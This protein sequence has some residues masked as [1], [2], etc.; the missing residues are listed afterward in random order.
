MDPIKFG[1]DLARKADLAH[2][3]AHTDF[4]WPD[5]SAHTLIITGMGSSAF[6]AQNVVTR[7]QNFGHNAIF[8]L[9]SNP[10]PPKPGTDKVLIA[11]SATGNSVET[12]AAFDNA[13][14]FKSKYWL[15]N[16][17]TL[18]ENAIAMRSGVESGGVACLSYL[19]T[20]IALLKLCE[21]LGYIKGLSNS[22]LL[23]AEA[24]ADIT[25][26]KE[27]WLPQLIDHINSPFG[28]YFI[29]PNDRICSAQQSALV[30]RECPRLPAVA[31]ETGDWSHIDVYLTK[32]IDYRAILFP[33]SIWQEQLLNWTTQR[34]TKVLTIGF[35][36]KS[37]AAILRYK[38]DLDPIVRLLAEITFIELLAQKIWQEN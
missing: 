28:T 35:E 14:G 19:A 2:K 10:T 3:L 37:A 4:N 26:R 7:L 20:Q 18:P 30:M 25:N 22:I 29:A 11:I 6:A 38:N 36:D 17:T 23:A 21:Q 27:Q 9:A 31:C 1:E 12:K 24:I 32:T 5:L 34:Q 15:T 16:S 13:Q 33:G 8:S